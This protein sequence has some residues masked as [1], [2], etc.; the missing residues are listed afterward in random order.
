[1]IDDAALED[2]VKKSNTI[3]PY[4]R[5]FVVSN[6]K[7]IT[8]KFIHAIN[9]F[10]TSDVFYTDTDSLYIEK[11]HWNNMDQVGLVGKRLLQGKNV[12]IFYGLFLAP[13]NKIRFDCQ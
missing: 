6:S 5:A 11:N 3:P 10:Y 13:K 7:R 8:N 12:G 9:G 4:L 1:M 2:E